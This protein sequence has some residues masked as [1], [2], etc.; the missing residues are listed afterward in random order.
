MASLNWSTLFAMNANAK[1]MPNNNFFRIQK[2]FLDPN[3]KFCLYKDDFMTFRNEFSMV[4]LFRI[5]P[6]TTT[7]NYYKNSTKILL[8]TKKESMAYLI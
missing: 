3:W 2:I 5:E 7:I 4:I 1:S 6:T 8:K